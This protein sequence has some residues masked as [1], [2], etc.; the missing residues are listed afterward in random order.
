MAAMSMAVM[1][2]LHAR[3]GAV[4]H[5]DLLRR[6]ASILAACIGWLEDNWRNPRSAAGV[7]SAGVV[8]DDWRV[9]F[10]IG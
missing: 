9:I 7:K 6:C 1:P 10:V 4:V 5:R 2:S 3:W 8:C